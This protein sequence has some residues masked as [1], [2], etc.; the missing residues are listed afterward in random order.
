[1]KSLPAHNR[2]AFTLVELLVVI[3]IIMIL[4]A[5]LLP[6]LRRVRE[7]AMNQACKSNLRQIG[8][9]LRMYANDNKGRYADPR[10]VGGSNCR[11]LFGERDPDDPAS[12]P[13]TYGWP[14]LLHQYLKS[15]RENNVWR[16]PARDSSWPVCY[17]AWTYFATPVKGHFWRDTVFVEENI[18]SY[19]YTTGKPAPLSFTSSDI[20]PAFYFTYLPMEKWQKAPHYY[21]LDASTTGQSGK[22]VLTFQPE[23]YSH[24]LDGDLSLHIV[25]HYAIYYFPN[26]GGYSMISPERVE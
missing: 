2:H 20:W 9:G 12:L 1:M 10:T 18:R 22:N 13:E 23:G 19:P 4:I 5:L 25:R 15:N 11:R 21:R 14:S 26:G 6:V 16:C 8:M 24:Y 17:N 3:A 7:A